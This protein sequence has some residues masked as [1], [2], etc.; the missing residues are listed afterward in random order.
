LR[1]ICIGKF[2]EERTE[3]PKCPEATEQK[4]AYNP[5]ECI[6]PPTPAPPGCVR[7]Q[8]LSD[9][10]L[11]LHLEYEGYLEPLSV[12][13]APNGLVPSVW[14]F[15]GAGGGEPTLRRAESPNSEGSVTG[16]LKILGYSGQELISAR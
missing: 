16:S 11:N 13:G 12:N 10:T 4:A 5:K 7:I 8:V 1:Q 9:P 6:T 15:E 3:L 2:N 14:E